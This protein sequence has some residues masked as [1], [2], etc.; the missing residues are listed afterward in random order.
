MAR[1][2]LCVALVGQPNVGKS[3]L[4]HRLTGSYAVVSNYPGTTVEFTRAEGRAGKQ[5]YMLVDTPGLYS[6][7]GKSEEEKATANWLRANR[8]RL[9]LQVV[10]MCN[11]PRMLKLTAE[12][13]ALRLPLVLVLN[14]ADE[15]ARAGVKVDI[16]LLSRLLKV[17][18]VATVSTT[19]Q[20]VSRLQEVIGE[21]LAK[22]QAPLPPPAVPYR[23]LAAS[24]FRGGPQKPGTFT[25]LADRLLLHPLWGWVFLGL[26]LYFGFYRFVGG[27]GAG[28][29]VNS[30]DF[31]YLQFLQ[32][33]LGMLLA[34]FLAEEWFLALFLG[35]YGIFSMGLRYA[36]T[37]VLPVITSFFLFFSLL[38]DSGYLPRLSYLLTK[39]LSLLGLNGKA[40]LPLTLGF[41]CG[42]MAVAVTRILDS[43][44][45]RFLATFLLA[46]GVPCSAQLGLMISLLSNIPGAFF[47]WALVVALTTL[48]AARLAHFLLPGSRQ[49]LL[50][51]LPP[52]RCPRLE[53]IWRK[54]SARVVWYFQEVLPLFMGISLFLWLLELTGLLQGILRALKL[55]LSWLGLPEETALVLLTGFFKRDYGAAGL[56]SL[57]RQGALGAKELLVA[58]VLLTLF[59]PCLAQL[60]LMLRE[61]GL[62]ETAAIVLLVSIIAFAVSFLVKTFLFI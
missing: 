8:P 42:T 10:D 60:F 5:K 7:H 22:G 51:E 54:T 40:V 58:S 15:A 24:C 1:S 57:Y 31:F 11:L 44:R 17:P 48:A 19:G 14:M 32:P 29:L 21:C 50:M 38:E 37:I 56:Y 3:L 59:L 27:I 9:I 12:L 26:L 52:L 46:L 39:P 53:A 13:A 25:R 55:P 18:V 43:R 33:M 6:L 61:R 62:K 36:L 35:E 45:E 41:G 30:L 4:F 47:S 28:Y 20:G 2:S 34:K 23:K 16:K 49:P